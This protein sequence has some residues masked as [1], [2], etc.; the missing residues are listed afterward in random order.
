MSASNIGATA[1]GAKGSLDPSS[2]ASPSSGISDLVE[3]SLSENGTNLLSIAICSSTDAMTAVEAGLADFAAVDAKLG[4]MLNAAK[5]TA[6]TQATQAIDSADSDDKPAKEAELS[7]TINIYD[8]KAQEFSSIVEAVVPEEQQDQG[9][10]SSLSTLGSAVMQIF[11]LIS[12][13]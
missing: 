5:E 3:S 4:E 7:A 11:T 1:S 10:I 2:N 13:N 12:R 6:I 8:S 9:T